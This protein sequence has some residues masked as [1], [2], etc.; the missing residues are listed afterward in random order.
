M[1]F[2]SNLVIDAGDGVTISGRD[3]PR[4]VSV[5]IFSYL[6]DVDKLSAS[7]SCAGMLAVGN[8]MNTWGTL[9]K[10][11]RNR[12]NIK[13]VSG[14]SKSWDFLIRNGAADSGWRSRLDYVSCCLAPKEPKYI[15]SS[16]DDERYDQETEEDLC[17][18]DLCLAT[19]TEKTYSKKSS[20]SLPEKQKKSSHCTS[21]HKSHR[22]CACRCNG[23][24][25]KRGFCTCEEHLEDLCREREASPKPNYQGNVRCEATP[26]V[27]I[28]AWKANQPTKAT[29][30]PKIQRESKKD[31][32]AVANTPEYFSHLVAKQRKY[33][34]L[35]TEFSSDWGFFRM[36]ASSAHANR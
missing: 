4:D 5:I 21:C 30:F 11:R 31:V 1:C 28:A 36:F 8:R 13:T 23:C 22:R 6:T 27:D 25:M 26:S 29:S 20:K 2:T 16:E 7:L 10:Q 17:S 33:T 9:I 15:Y 14:E 32:P 34:S 24:D 18:F 3:I 19:H 35:C 12:L